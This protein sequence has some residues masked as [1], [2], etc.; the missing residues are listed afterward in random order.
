MGA[1]SCCEVLTARVQ[2]GLRRGCRLSGVDPGGGQGQV[3]S[4]RGD[5]TVSSIP[6]T[7]TWPDGGS[8]SRRTLGCPPNVHRERSRSPFGSRRRRSE[9]HGK[10]KGPG[11]R[12]SDL[13]LRGAAFGVRTRDLLRVRWT[14]TSRHWRLTDCRAS[15]KPPGASITLAVASQSEIAVPDRC[16]A[17]LWPQAPGGKVNRPAIVRRAGRRRQPA[18]TGPGPLPTPTRRP[19]PADFKWVRVFLWTRGGR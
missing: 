5:P 7:V 18:S 15:L 17:P 8:G 19:E 1:P 3:L 2:D 12:H 4:V 11:Q 6:N 16:G 9:D 10:A 14:S 13:G